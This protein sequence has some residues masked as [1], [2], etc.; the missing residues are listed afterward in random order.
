M[1]FKT[2][3]PP[4]VCFKHV[5]CNHGISS[6]VVKDDVYGGS[7]LLV[8]FLSVLS[9]LLDVCIQRTRS[10]QPF[11]AALSEMLTTFHFSIHMVTLP[12]I[13]K[14][15]EVVYSYS[16]NP[17][18]QI[19]TTWLGVRNTRLNYWQ[20]SKTKMKTK[21]IPL[22]WWRDEVRWKPMSSSHFSQSTK[23][24]LFRPQEECQDT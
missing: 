20:W 17:H 19:N 24:D 23:Q 9:S 18:L 2:T 21:I 13:P 5:W 3:L 8:L 11:H 4:V 15:L 14:T 22:S 12:Q 10:T 1:V 6:G 7:W 16:N